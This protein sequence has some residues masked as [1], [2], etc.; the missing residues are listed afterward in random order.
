MYLVVQEACDLLII[1]NIIV[2]FLQSGDDLVWSDHSPRPR[3]PDQ[4]HQDVH[5]AAE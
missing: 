1:R 3:R 4:L 2:L 5:Y